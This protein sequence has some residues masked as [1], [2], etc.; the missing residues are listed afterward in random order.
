MSDERMRALDN[1]SSDR[2]TKI[3]LSLSVML[4]GTSDRLARFFSGSI[5]VD[6]PALTAA[7]SFSRK[8][9]IGSTLPLR[10]ISPV[11]AIP[12]LTGIPVRALATAVSIAIPA[13]GPSF[14]TAP[15]GT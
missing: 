14:G 12:A 9:P 1:T 13:D 5:T 6:I 15:S 7:R 10:V 2:L 3:M 11:I 8:P 4:S